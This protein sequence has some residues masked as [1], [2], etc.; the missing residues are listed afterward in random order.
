MAVWVFGRT[1]GFKSATIFC[2]KS[3]PVPHTCW[4]R[5]RRAWQSP[6]KRICRESGTNPTWL[7]AFRSPIKI[8]SF[9]ICQRQLY[10]PDRPV[11]VAPPSWVRTSD[12]RIN[13]PSGELA[14]KAREYYRRP[15]DVGKY[16]PH[17]TVSLLRFHCL[18][19][20]SICQPPSLSQASRP[21]RRRSS[22]EGHAADR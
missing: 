5:M 12:L 21:A 10:L 1:L 6:E 9:Y 19:V 8:G 7:G 16:F 15:S 11:R 18:C 3:S 20:R 14:G 22:A 4:F 2:R 17:L 13:S